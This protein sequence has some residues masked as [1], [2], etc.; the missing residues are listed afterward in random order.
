MQLHILRRYFDLFPA[1]KTAV[2]LII[3]GSCHDPNY[4]T[5]LKDL[6]WSLGINHRVDFIV[7]VPFGKVLEELQKAGIG[8]H[9]MKDEHFGIGIV[10]LMLA[11]AIPIAHNSGGPRDDIIK[12]DVGF[13]AS[14]VDE[15]VDKLDH[16]FQL[17][18]SQRG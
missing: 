18:Q 10:E 9:T 6:A 3:L 8:L 4:L 17:Q 14:D 15:Y 7:N 16:I 11:G 2:R 1:R 5:G 12:E 13:L